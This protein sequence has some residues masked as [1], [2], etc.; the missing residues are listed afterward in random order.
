MESN[1]AAQPAYDITL[2][3]SWVNLTWSDRPSRRRNS[4]CFGKEVPDTPRGPNTRRDATNLH[5]TSFG[6][7]SLM[8]S[9]ELMSESACLYL[10]I[11]S[12]L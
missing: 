6:R 11:A 4:R 2:K 3:M 1:Q 5:S 8:I 7:N 10:H 9:T 12:H